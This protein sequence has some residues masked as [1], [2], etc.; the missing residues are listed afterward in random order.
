M[1]VY[2]YICVYKKLKSILKHQNQLH[3]P[4]IHKQPDH[5]LKFLTTWQELH[6]PRALFLVWL[7]SKGLGNRVPYSR[8]GRYPKPFQMFILATSNSNI[9]RS[10]QQS[11]QHVD[12]AGGYCVQ[13]RRQKR[14]RSCRSVRPFPVLQVGSWMVIPGFGCSFLRVPV[15]SERLMR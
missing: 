13:V 3:F 12:L 6:I 10:H 5:D 8:D 4:E 1:Y 14:K 2:I 11:G 9:N 15:P 7:A